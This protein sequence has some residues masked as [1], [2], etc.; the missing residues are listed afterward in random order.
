MDIDR[1]Q[2]INALAREY[3]KHGMATSMDEAV[4]MAED[5]FRDAFGER[6]PNPAAMKAEKQAAQ[7]AAQQASQQP[8]A[9]SNIDDKSRSVVSELTNIVEAQAK[10]IELISAKMNEMIKEINDMKEQVEKASKPFTVPQTGADGQTQF[11]KPQAE[12]PKNHARTGNYKP[13]DISVEKFFYSGSGS[14]RS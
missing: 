2:K 11:K 6:L 12:A 1:L 5:K 9:S 3:V 14:P 4:R 7:Q 13:G 10:Q 8:Q